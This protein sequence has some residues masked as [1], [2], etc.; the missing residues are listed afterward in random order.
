MNF[1][2]ARRLNLRPGF[3]F[4][5]LVIAITI[6][7]IL[8]M[9]ATRSFLGYLKDARETSTQATLRVVKQE[10][11]HYFQKIGKYPE[12]LKDLVRKPADLTARQWGGPYIESEEAPQDGWKNELRYKVVPG[13]HPPFELYSWGENGPDSPD[14]ER[15]YPQ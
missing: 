15:I 2:Q 7:A 1:M 12:T 4:I 11:N 3:T 14:E 10:I 8:G 5:E 6:L 13:S 9:V